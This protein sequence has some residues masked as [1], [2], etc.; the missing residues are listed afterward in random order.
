M[1]GIYNVTSS[2]SHSSQYAVWKLFTPEETI[3]S[4]A[5]GFSTKLKL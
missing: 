1:N 4:T 3:G 5:L 2:S